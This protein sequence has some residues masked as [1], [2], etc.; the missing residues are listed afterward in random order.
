MAV[1]LIKTLPVKNYTL[2]FIIIIVAVISLALLSRSP[3][4][5]AINKQ[6][7][8]NYR[9]FISEDTSFE[10]AYPL[11]IVVPWMGKIAAFSMDSSAIIQLDRK[12][13][14]SKI[15]FYKNRRGSSIH[16][17]SGDSNFLYCFNPNDH[18]VLKSNF[19]TPLQLL[20][21]FR[22]VY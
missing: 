7:S 6:F 10:T 13:I 17:I 15:P 1:L 5:M 16:S 21:V 12:G 14:H 8:R 9:T 22:M 19:Q 3:K 11:D 20:I 2:I 4:E 18:L